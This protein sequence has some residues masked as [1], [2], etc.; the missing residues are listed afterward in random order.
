MSTSQVRAVLFADTRN[1][2][3]L[4]VD[5]G[6]DAA[7][8]TVGE[9]MARCELLIGR[10]GG[11]VIKRL[12]DGLMASFNDAASAVSSAVAI[13]QLHQTG[14]IHLGIGIQSGEVILREADLFGDACNEAAR[15]CSLA[16]PDEIL[17]G[18][19]LAEKLPA[20]GF[21]LQSIDKFKIKGKDR[22]I[23]VFRVEWEVVLERTAYVPAG[24][25]VRTTPQLRITAR[26]GEFV[27][28][29]SRP[30]LTIGRQDCDLVIANQA[31]SRRHAVIQWSDGRFILSDQSTNGTTIRYASGQENFIRREDTDI[32]GAGIIALG[33]VP[34]LNALCLRFECF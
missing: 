32:V 3:K 23:D 30:R 26:D 20:G 33:P 7:A 5:I 18:R 19:D 14:L 16:L 12:G 1:S 13:Q 10:A 34:V 11:S 8:A 6:N 22:P 27:I 24:E 28:D 4:Y 15:L 31:V 2:T 25:A 17:I 29:R 9:S 21:V